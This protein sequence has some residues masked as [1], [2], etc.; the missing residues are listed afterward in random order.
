MVTGLFVQAE[1]AGKTFQNVLSVPRSALY[2]KNRLLVLD[3]QQQLQIVTVQVLQFSDEQAL[4]TGIEQGKKV[5]LER[6]G[7]VIEGMPI[8]PVISSDV[9]TGK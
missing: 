8:E 9:A 3:D 4:V 2:E 5:L 7:Y 1:I 6:P